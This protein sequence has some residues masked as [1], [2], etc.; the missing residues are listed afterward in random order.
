VENTIEA[1]VE[2]EDNLKDAS[3]S[4]IDDILDKT[5]TVLKLAAITIYATLATEDNIG[6]TDL[7]KALA[8]QLDLK[9][10]F[11]SAAI[12]AYVDANQELVIGRGKEGGIWFRAKH[13][14]A[15]LLRQEAKDA[16]T[17]SKFSATARELGFTEEQFKKAKRELLTENPTI[18]SLK[19][20]IA[21]Q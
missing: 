13:E 16:K 8:A 19:E 12:G 14:A 6:I 11:V 10:A 7:S 5:K 21:K 18:K 17:L 15:Q 20:W 4:A 2:Y 9:Q 3:G 1:A